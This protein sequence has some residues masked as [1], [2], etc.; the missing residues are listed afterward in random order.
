MSEKTI[1]RI[2][3]LLSVVV[4]GAVIILNRRVLPVPAEFPQFVYQLPKVNALINGT[5]AVLLLLSLY[6]IRKKNIV[7]H[8][9]INLVAFFLS[10]LF[11]VCYITYHWL[12]EETIFP[13]DNSL[14][15]VY[16]TILVSHIILAGIVLP[17]I[18]MSFWYGLKN[19][20][21]KHRKLVRFT[22]PVWLYVCITGPVIYLMISPYY[23]FPGLTP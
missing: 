8:K 19:D 17:M 12:V 18:L 14:R 1:F 2:V 23:R 4:L 10:A 9:R 13:K 15:P 20:I 11:L 3:L 22:Y 7:M 6:F 16:M 5:C 21:K